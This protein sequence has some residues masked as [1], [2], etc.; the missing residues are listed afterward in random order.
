[1]STSQELAA[2]FV[3]WAD[4]EHL[5]SYKPRRITRIVDRERPIEVNGETASPL[6]QTEIAEHELDAIR[7]AFRDNRIHYVGYADNRIVIAAPAKIAAERKLPRSTKGGIWLDFQNWKAPDILP[8]RNAVRPSSTLTMVG[9]RYPCGTSISTGDD[10]SAGTFGCLV[11]DR[12]GRLFGL[13]NNHVVGQC[14]DADPKLPIVAPGLLDVQAD[15]LDP[16]TLG[17]FEKLSQVTHGIPQNVATTA[18]LD[19]AIFAIRNEDAVTSMQQRFYD[20]PTTTLPPRSQMVVEKVGRTT[21]HT[22]GVIDSIAVNGV[23]VRMEAFRF[24][25]RVYFD[26]CFLVRGKS[27]FALRGDSGSLIV[28]EEKDEKRTAIGIV[29]AVNAERGITYAVPID[30]VLSRFDITLVGNHHAL[31]NTRKTPSC[32]AP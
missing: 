18:N 8:A 23:S 13:S 3:A 26:N 12:Q 11:R 28:S 7:G 15:G 1:M 30:D 27:D 16:F 20:T 21:G 5:L 24:K 31:P 10:I 22:T 29:F 19:A 4:N 6:L 2:A 14:N 32:H 17:H 9:P 25:G